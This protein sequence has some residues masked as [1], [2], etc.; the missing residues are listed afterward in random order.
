MNSFRIIDGEL[1]IDKGPGAELIYG[2]DLRRW[3]AEGETLDT[4]TVTVQGVEKVSET[5]EGTQVL[6]WIKGGTVGEP[7]SATYQW[8]TSIGGVDERTLHFNITDR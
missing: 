8:T 1:E 4:L 7:A 2:I 5:I 3:L 6:A